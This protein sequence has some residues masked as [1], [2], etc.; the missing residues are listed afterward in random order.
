MEFDE[1]FMRATGTAPYPWQRGVATSGLPEVIDVE[2][3][4]GK[5][6]GVV[7][8]WLYRRLH[9]DDPEVRAATPPWLVF[10]LPMRSLVDQ[11]FGAVDDWLAATGD[12]DEVACF[13]LIG[14]EGRVENAWR[15][16]PGRPTVIVGT[17]DMVLSRALMRGYG[18]SRWVWPIDFGL[19]HAGCHFVFDEVQLLGPALPTGRQL[20]G[21]RRSIGT[22]APCSSTWMSATLDVDRLVTVDHPEVSE[23]VRL[24]PADRA[25]GLAVRLGAAKTIEE[26]EAAEPPDLAALVA[27]VHRPGSRTL[28]VVNLVKRAQEVARLLRRHEVVAGVPVD[29]L[30]SR[31]RSA[32]RAAIIAGGALGLV[33][34]AGPGRILVATQVVEAGMDLSSRT[35]VTDAAPWSSIVQRAGR[36]NRAGEFDD[37]RL[38]WV[39]PPRPAP[40]DEVT[41]A[42][43]VAALRSLRG[44][45]VTATDLRELS[46]HVLETEPIV[47]VL[48]RRDLVDLF[49]TAPDLV[50]NDVDVSR[51]IRSGDDTDVQ[52]AWRPPAAEPDARSPFYGGRIR[53]DELCSVSIGDARTWLRTV[54]AWAPDHLDARRR[55]RRVEAFTVR[56]GATVVVAVDQGG[57]HPERGW[58]PGAKSPV[59]A[60][61]VATSHHGAT[62]VAPLDE[63]T[64][65]D[66]ATFIGAWVGLADHLADTETAA[67]EILDEA[68]MSDLNADLEA[69][70]VRAAALHDLGKAHPVF[71]DTLVRSA[72]EDRRRDAEALCPLAKSGGT[73]KARHER[74]HFRHELVSALLLASHVESVLGGDA[75]PDLIRYLVAAHHGRVRLAIRSIPGERAPADRQGAR[76][77]LGVADGDVVPAITAG[78]TRLD[79]TTLGLDA[80]ALGGEGSWTAMALGLRD[81]LDLG[82]FRLATLEALVRLADWRASGAPT[83]TSNIEPAGGR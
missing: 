60:I 79:A 24:T 76:V 63:S 72:G 46:R 20:E 35:L 38:F 80:M 33:D 82:P 30:H 57:Y 66:P 81:R 10:A 70:V 5:T 6:A 54:I 11:T 19:L 18:A 16:R 1:L 69:A 55:W 73:A 83:T 2:T 36:C 21:L 75:E 67:R 42:A 45:A 48:R 8:G 78:L 51:F 47:P 56:P 26:A 41:I 65:D 74:P 25:Q 17:V 43:S 61:E 14:G 3:G 4:A 27:E 44:R 31:F 22:A 71:Q 34:T 37:A 28:V 23:P 32:D 77:A 40:Y 53:P 62:E 50:G 64:A 68:A 58:D 39:E 52:V 49:D 7:L 9:H 29:L 13:R 12:A 59:P 15:E